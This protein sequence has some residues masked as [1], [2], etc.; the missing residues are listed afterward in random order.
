MEAASRLR[1]ADQRLL[2]GQVRAGRALCLLFGRAY[3]VLP[4]ANDFVVP[5]LKSCRAA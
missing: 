4:I 5:D 3:P 1:R 2:F